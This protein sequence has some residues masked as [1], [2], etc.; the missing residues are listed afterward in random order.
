[1]KKTFILFITYVLIFIWISFEPAYAER[2]ELGGDAPVWAHIGAKILLYA[3]IAGG[4]IGIFA[5][6]LAI[7]ARKGAPIHRAAGKV[8]FISMFIAYAIGAGVA[9]FLHTG[10]RPNFVAGVLALYLLITAWRTVR[11]PK[12]IPGAFEY[13]GL[14]LAIGVVVL[15][16][17]FM[18]MGANDPSGT[19]DGSPPQAFILFAV[20]GSFAAA[21]DL[22]LIA[23]KGLEGAA[24]I[25]RHLWRMCFSFFIAST[26]LFLGQPRVFPDWFSESLA[27]V[28][29]SFA[30]L[31]ALLIWISIIGGRRALGR[32]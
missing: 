8:F 11:I 13:G 19:I 28:A 1:M 21:G 32:A 30:P 10:Q 17:L 23:G 12:I 24:R 26:S 22:H 27:P 6:T 16:V 29:L 4:T 9:P 18:Q 20:A 14:L 7:G 5:G 15:G 3:H 25:A 31:A 2:L